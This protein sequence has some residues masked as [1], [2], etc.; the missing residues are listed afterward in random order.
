MEGA[1]ARAMRGAR[2]AVRC[3]RARRAFLQ[4]HGPHL[5]AGCCGVARTPAGGPIPA[6]A[7]ARVAGHAVV[8]H[9]LRPFEAPLWVEPRLRQRAHVSGSTPMYAL[10]PQLI[11][12]LL[13]WS[14]DSLSRKPSMRRPPSKMPGRLALMWRNGGDER[15]L[16]NMGGQEAKYHESMR[17][18]LPTTGAT[19]SDR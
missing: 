4:Q 19:Q 16:R 5:G 9:E 8:E 10:F 12:S 14:S 6:V 1:R 13:A 3:A 15:K 7:V 2:G 11:S 17:S 18:S